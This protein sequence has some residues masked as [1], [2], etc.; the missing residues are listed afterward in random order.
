MYELG[1]SKAAIVEKRERRFLMLVAAPC[2]II[3]GLAL[4]AMF[5][6]RSEVMGVNA[7]LTALLF[8]A[9]GIATGSIS[10]VKDSGWHRL[11]SSTAVFAGI[12][13]LS[14]LW[15]EGSPVSFGKHLDTA[16]A[17]MQKT[18]TPAASGTKKSTPA[19]E[20]NSLLEN[21]Q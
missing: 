3:A 19:V 15:F 14:S 21:G 16:S 20:A 1:V 4:G 17:A 10:V 6:N 12:A 13:V 2:A 7:Q 5:L 9:A 18:E 11:I 8:A